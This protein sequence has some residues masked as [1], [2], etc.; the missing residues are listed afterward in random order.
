MTDLPTI[1][2][3]YR[4]WICVMQAFTLNTFASFHFRFFYSFC[5]THS[6]N[7]VGCRNL[8]PVDIRAV[9]FRTKDNLNHTLRCFG[10][11]VNLVLILQSLKCDELKC[12]TL[13]LTTHID[14]KK[15]KKRKSQNKQI[16][17]FRKVCAHEIHTH[18]QNELQ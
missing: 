17:N 6:S 10:Y 2:C 5:V 12:D 9:K 3:E 11:F 13:Q 15:I 1:V 7:H 8:Q 16:W 4:Y 18:S 14:K